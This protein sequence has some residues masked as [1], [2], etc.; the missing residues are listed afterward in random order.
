MMDAVGR[1]IGAAYDRITADYAV[2]NAAM[3][4]D[5]LALGARFL[6]LVRPRRPRP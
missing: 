5:L 1:R 2:R 6:M 4:P 3:P